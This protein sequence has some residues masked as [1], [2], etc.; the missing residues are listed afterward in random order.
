MKITD[1]TTAMMLSRIIKL[2]SLVRELREERAS[3]LPSRGSVI[4]PERSEAADPREG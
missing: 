3:R 2:E 1:K 4:K